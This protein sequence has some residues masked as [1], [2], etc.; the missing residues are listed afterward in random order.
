MFQT[1]WG[2]IFFLLEKFQIFFSFKTFFRPSFHQLELRDLNWTQNKACRLKLSTEVNLVSL[3]NICKEIAKRSLNF[4]FTLAEVSF[5]LHFSNHP[6]HPTKK[7][8]FDLILT[9]T[10]PILK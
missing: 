7:V 8:K 9:L 5:H 4:N 2:I 1:E 3:V 6:P 10:E